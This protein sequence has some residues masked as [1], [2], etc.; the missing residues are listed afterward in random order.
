MTEAAGRPGARAAIRSVVANPALRRIEIAWMLGTAG[1]AAFL[2]ALLLAAFAYG[3][4]AAV[5]ILTVV[6]MAP[7]VLGAPLAGLLAGR[8]PPTRLLF[9]AHGLRALGAVV[10]TL[11]L[12]TGT[13]PFV[14][15]LAAMVAA[16]AGAFVR[17][18]Q[19]TA[20]P[21]LARSP[22]E[23]VASN[24]VSSGGEGIGAFAGPL[25]AGILV[26]VAGPI[27]ASAAATAMFI[28]GAAALVEGTSSPDDRAEEDAEEG[29]RVSQP[30]AIAMIA[31]ELTAGVRTLGR[32][33]AAAT[34]MA[35]LA[36]QVFV[37]GLMT[38]LTV[39]AAIRL[40]GLGE[41]GV[42]ALVAAS[43][44]GTLVGA[45]VAIRLASSRALGPTYAVSLSTW[46]LPLAIVAAFP[47]PLIAILGLVISGIANA[48]LDVAGFTLLQRSV[49]RGERIAVFGLLES[50]VSLGVALGAAT[51]PV[52][53]EQLGDRGAL[54]VAGAILPIIAVAS[55]GGLRRAD[56]EVVL[57]ER[58][59]HLLRGV[60]LFA[61][62]PLTALERL[63]EAL[64]SV[65]ASAGDTIVREGEPGRDYYLI[66]TGEVDVLVGGRVLA[67]SG[68]GEGFGEIALLHD[69]PRT[70][71]VVVR[72]DVEL[73][74]LGPADFLAAVAG[75][76]SAAAA[77]A[78]VD[79]RL[80]RSATG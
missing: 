57:P 25:S 2:V 47:H 76:T 5:G 56:D 23:L 27:A 10:A 8:R 60:P 54:A 15:L 42:G 37:R 51:A 30:L 16:S 20:M 65:H 63:A 77:A 48:I 34:I 64:R 18:L 1:D 43:G 75:P 40:V 14:V 44:L 31:R 28:V 68:P 22:D 13:M 9:L 73:A 78:V 74:V 19:T 6:R 52:L 72:T 80:A 79:E 53:I 4:T 33:R 3:G 46:G 26:A 21:S 58:Q 11:A 7:S 50:V 29:S 32:H 41:P 69:V 49:P 66:V 70:A 35:G 59:L 38:S 62:L 12:A 71:T 45:V 39:V 36:G 61:P 67:R 55:W 17:P 24:V